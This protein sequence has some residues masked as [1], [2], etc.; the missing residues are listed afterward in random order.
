MEPIILIHSNW[1]ESGFIPLYLFLGGLSAG[2]FI[3]A[4]CADFAQA[5]S[6]SYAMVAKLAVYTA[7][8][9]WALGSLFV[10]I[11]LS[12]PLQGLFFPLF[13]SNYGSWMTYGGW[14]MGLGGP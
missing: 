7:F 5:R 9:A 2:L 13:F 6:K 8:P 1:S 3:V 10:I 14:A 4:I 12:K 11:H